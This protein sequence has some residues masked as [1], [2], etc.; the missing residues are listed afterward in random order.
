MNRPECYVV[1][2]A[3]RDNSTKSHVTEDGITLQLKG[4]K[5]NLLHQGIIC[6][7]A[8]RTLEVKGV[9]DSNLVGLA[10]AKFRDA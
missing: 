5:Q 10:L 3:L 8:D 7:Q 1:W 9:W 6:Q 2:E 4:T